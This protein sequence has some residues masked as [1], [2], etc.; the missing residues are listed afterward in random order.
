MDKIAEMGRKLGFGQA[1]DVGISGV[2]SG[3]MPDPAWKQAKLGTGWRMGDTL[4]AGIGQ[5]F[6][7][8]TPLQLAVMTGRIANGRQAI[9]PTLIINDAMKQPNA[10]D[11]NPAHLD[12]VRDAMRAVCHEP[13]GTAYRP[14]PLGLEVIEMAGKTGTGQV[15]GISATERLSRLR[16]NRELPWKLRDHS[17]FVGYAPYDRPRFAVG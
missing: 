2:K 17:I 13:G 15:R 1:F 3:I 12:Y 11:I 10:L 9:T 16:K 14:D 6:V 8:A 5:G 4:N 7:L